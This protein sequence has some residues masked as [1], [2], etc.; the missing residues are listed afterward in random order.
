MIDFHHR[1]TEKIEQAERANKVPPQSIGEG[2][3]VGLDRFS[4][5]TCLVPTF[6]MLIFLLAIPVNAQDD[7]P[8]YDLPDAF[9]YPAFSSNSLVAL[10]GGRVA[11][12][13]M[14]T[15]S[16][17]LVDVRLNELIVEIPVGNDPRSVD[18]TPDGSRLLVTNRGNDSLFVI[19]IEA[20]AVIATHFVDGQP[21]SVITDNNNT[22][23]ISLQGDNAV[24]EIDIATGDI[25]QFIPTPN[26]PTGL[27]IWGDF[28]YVT[29]FH[30]SD[31]S[32]IYTPVG[33][34]VRTI[35][36]GINVGLS[37]FIYVDHRNGLAYV[38]QSITYPDSTNPTFDRTVRPRVIVIDLAQMRVLRDRTLWLDIAD[39]PVNMPFS[40]ALN[41]AQGRLFVLNAGSNDL[42][43]IDL[44]TGLALWN[45]AL[46]GNPRGLVL[47]SDGTFIYV[48][49]AIDTALSIIETRFYSVEDTI[50]TSINL[51]DLE[52]QIGAELFHTTT[53]VHVSGTQYLSCA[54]CH[55]EGLSD[56]RNW[57]GTVAPTFD[58][59]ADDFD[60]NG[61]IKN[62][63][64]GT[65]FD[66]LST[67]EQSA[68]V[69][70][71]LS[72]TQT[73]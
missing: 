34:V 62:F 47:A 27:A 59:I 37:P 73:D 60:L 13:N 12:A 52:T 32:L 42:S 14:L 55:I 33:D 58:T 54:S 31:I 25:L 35:S 18:V 19:D 24:V 10:S 38:P 49:H 40:V 17:S 67:F 53:D 69:N 15:D 46:E 20:Q 68:L 7:L 5:R 51:P 45:T 4:R 66:D 44:N 48:Q 21:Y 39:R 41:V 71:M 65:G 11:V 63:T 6:L 72:L 56:G 64:Y 3:R 29:H 50:P 23:Y 70:Y 61:H 43:V 26:T 30:T 28:L 9:T 57:Y 1:G 16:V 22:A 36:T 2:F 8:L